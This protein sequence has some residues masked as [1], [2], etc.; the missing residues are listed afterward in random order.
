MK[1]DSQMVLAL[2]EA[3]ILNDELRVQNTIRR[4]RPNRRP[5]GA[6]KLAKAKRDQRELVPSA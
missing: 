3:G 6:Q 4:H 1:L 2:K 5:T